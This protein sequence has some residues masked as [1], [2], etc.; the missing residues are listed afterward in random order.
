MPM[1]RR[2]GECGRDVDG[3]VTSDQ[4]WMCRSSP[5][6]IVRAI[7]LAGVQRAA[8]V[9]VGGAILKSPEVPCDYVAVS[10]DVT[11]RGL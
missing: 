9:L 1:G 3:V 4:V 8:D 10:R 7:E 5:Y 6:L 11:A 2:F